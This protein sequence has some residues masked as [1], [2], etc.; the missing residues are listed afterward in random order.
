MK[1]IVSGI[2]PRRP[3]C[4]QHKPLCQVVIAE[5]D[6]PALGRLAAIQDGIRLQP[7]RTTARHLVLKLNILQFGQLQ[8]I[9]TLDIF[10]GEGLHAVPPSAEVLDVLA[11]RLVALDDCASKTSVDQ[12]SEILDTLGAIFGIF[13]FLFEDVDVKLPGLGIES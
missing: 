8:V 1:A 7:H 5:I 3:V 2:L 6:N 12:D 10:F 11:S 4:S 13:D 9:G